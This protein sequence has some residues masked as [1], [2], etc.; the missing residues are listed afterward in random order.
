MCVLGWV[1]WRPATSRPGAVSL[2]EA[3]RKAK[4]L[5]PLGRRVRSVPFPL[6]E[7]RVGPSPMEKR[8]SSQGVVSGEW[9]H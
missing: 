1:K 3:R 8:P 9:F 6:V 7:A 5:E 2:K 4:A